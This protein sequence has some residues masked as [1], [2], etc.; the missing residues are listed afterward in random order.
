MLCYT[1]ISTTISVMLKAT[2]VKISIFY[3]YIILSITLCY[4]VIYGHV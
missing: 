1:V 2:A 4:N 3:Y